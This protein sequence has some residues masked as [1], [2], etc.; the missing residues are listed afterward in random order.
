MTPG[1]Q[2]GDCLFI[3]PEQ[4]EARMTRLARSG[5][6]ILPLGEAVERLGAGTLPDAAVAITIG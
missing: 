1:H 5:L 4:F 2:F 6:P 3:P